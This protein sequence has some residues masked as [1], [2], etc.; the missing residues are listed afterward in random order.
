MSRQLA[1][2]ETESGGGGG[3]AI[4]S[5]RYVAF[6]DI[7]GFSSIVIFHPIPARSIDLRPS[8][9]RNYAGSRFME[10]KWTANCETSGDDASA[11]PKLCVLRAL[12]GFSPL[13]FGADRRF[14]P[15][16]WL[17]ELLQPKQVQRV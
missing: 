16:L 17:A 15:V 3:Q 6:V 8:N 11:G 2:E 12:Y 9:L 4:Y 7:F 13:G 1:N 10:F 14:A 5:E